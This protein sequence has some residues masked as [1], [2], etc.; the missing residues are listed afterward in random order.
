[1]ENC[2]RG[3]ALAHQNQHESSV[4]S[5]PR[6]GCS[7]E[8]LEKLKLDITNSTDLSPITLMDRIRD[9]KDSSKQI[10]LQTVINDET[11]VEITIRWNQD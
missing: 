9:Y 11:K 6:R 4:S 3:F 2:L 8:Q 5:H 10:F 7:E 1:L